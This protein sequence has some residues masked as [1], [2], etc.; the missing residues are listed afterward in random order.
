MP[1]MLNKTSPILCQIYKITNTVNGKVYIGQTWL[2]KLQYR[3]AKEAS[4][5]S[6]CT[7]LYN[8]I[9]KYGKDK[10]TFEF[11]TVCHTQEVADHLEARFIDQYDSRNKN[12]GYNLKTAGSFGKHTDKSKEKIRQSLIG[13]KRAAPALL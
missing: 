10:F 5:S 9:A 3:W 8:A 6:H 12:K 7:Y 4:A 11:L 13:N 1:S 2:Y